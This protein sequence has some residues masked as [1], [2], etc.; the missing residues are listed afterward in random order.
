[1]SFFRVQPVLLLLILAVCACSIFSISLVFAQSPTINYQGKLTTSTGVAVPNGTYEMEFSLYTV[2]TGGTAVWTET[3]SGSNE[4]TVTDGLFSVMLGST[5]AL[6][7]VDFSQT[8]YLGVSIEADAE[9]SPRKILGTV[10]AAFEAQNAETFGT[11][12]TTSFVRSDQ[13]DSIVASTSGTLFSVIQNGAGTVFELFSGL[14]NLFTV[15]NSGNVGIGSSTPSAKLTVTGNG[16]FG[17]NLTATGTLAVTGT[18]TLTDLTL[19]GGLRDNAGNRGTLGMVLQTTG[20][21]TRWVATSTLGFGSSNVATLN[22]LT[23]VT[24]TAASTGELLAYNGSQWVD[25]AT[26]TLGIALSDTIGILA[27]TR[28]GTG[29]STVSVNQLLIGGAGNTWNQ[30]ATS[31]LGLSAQFTDSTGLAALLSDEQGTSGGFV[32][33]SSSMLTNTT[34]INASSTLGFTLSGTTYLTGALRDNNNATG[35][36]GMV[37]QTTG[38]ST[39]WVATSTL[40]TS[41]A[42][43]DSAGLAGLLSDEQGT[44]G[45]FVRASSSFL[46]APTFLNASSTNITL[47]GVT[48]LNGALRDNNNATGTLGMVLQTTGTSTRWVATSTLGTSAAFTDSTGLAALLSDEQGTSGGFVRASSSMLTN[49]TLINAS[50]TLGFTLSGT[51]YLTGALRDNNNA[52]GTL[53]MVLQTTGTSTRWVATSTLG[54][55]SS[56]VATLND[57]TDVTITAASTGELLAYNGSQWV[58]VATSTLGIALSDTIGILAPTRGGTGTSTVSVNQLLIGGAGNTWNQ[59][60]T[61]SLGL[62]NGTF[63][64]LTD[65]PSSYTANSLFYTNGAGTAVTNSANL[66]F[67]GTNLGVGSSTPNATLSV[68][69]DTY[70]TG[71][72][73]VG[74]VNT[75]P[76]TLATV[77]N[78]TIGNALTVQGTGSVF[79]GSVIVSYADAN[80]FGTGLDVRK[81]GTT[82]DATA[83]ITNG[84]ELGY[85]GFLGW[86]GSAYVRGAYVIANATENWTGSQRGTSY[87]IAV[88][89]NGSIANTVALTLGQDRTAQFFGNVNVSGTGTSAFTGAV[90]VTGTTTLTDLTLQG[91]LRDNAGSRGTLGMVLQTSGTST[92]WVATSSLGFSVGHSPVTLA[93]ENYLSLLGQEITANEIGPTNLANLDF[94]DFSCNGTACFLDAVYLS[95]LS[96][97][98]LFD[99][100]D[101][102]AMPSGSLFYASAIDTPAA[103]SIGAEGS[104]LRVVAGLPAWTATSTLGLGNGTFLGLSDTPSSYA[105]NRI[106]YMT[107]SA[108]TTSSGFVFDG[109]NLGVG[110]SSPTARIMIGDGAQTGAQ[111]FRNL[112]AV[113]DIW[114][115]QSANTHFG[116][117]SGTAALVMQD[118]NRDFPLV[119]GNMNA[120]P[121]VFGTQNQERM[122]IHSDGNVSIGTTTNSAGLLLQGDALITD[123]LTVGSGVADILA[124]IAIGDGTRT[125]RQWFRN[126]GSVSDIFIGQGDQNMFGLST[127]STAFIVQNNSNNSALAIGNLNNQ[128]LVFGT[129]DLERM[130]IGADGA[131]SINESL[132][133]G[134]GLS[135]EDSIT[136]TGTVTT[137]FVTPV[138][139][140][141]TTRINVPIYTP[142]AFAQVIAM[143]I[144]STAPSTA[145]VLSL[146]DDRRTA[147]QPTLAVFAPDE[148]NLVG[149]SW[150]GSNTTSYLKTTGGNVGI[151]SNTTDI[152]TFLGT[153]ESVFSGNVG[154]GSST[155]SAKLT[156]TGNGFFGGNLTATGTLAVTGTTTLTDLTLTGGLRDN[157]GNRGTLG[158]V[159]QTT[160]TSTRWVATSTLGFGSS[161]VATLNDLTDVTITAAST[162]EL[163]AYNGSQWVDVATST[164]GI[165]L[166]DTIGILAPTRGGTGT[167][168]VSVNQLLI[169][170]AGNTWNQI[171][172]SSLGLSAQFTDSTGLAALLSDE[173]GTSGGFVRASSSMLTNTT[174]INASSTLGFTLSGTTYLTGALRDNNNATGTL[175]M[176]LQTTGTSTRWVAT[177]TLGFGSSNVATL[178]DLTDVT[179]T[180][181]STG[182]LLAYNGS[183][184]VDVATSTLGIALSDTIGIL[185]P[186]RGGTGT[187]TV[188]VNQLLI[189]G[190][191]NTWNQ[192]ATSSLGLSAQFTDS[193]GLAALL[194]DEQGTSGGFVR[195][196]SSMLTNTTLINAS[197]TLG[198]TLSG[199]TYLTGA[200]RDNNNA[201]GT[202]G[203]VLQTTGTSTRWVATST[204]GFGSSNVATLN[205]LTD[206]TITAASTGELLAYNGS[207]WVDVAT[208][209]L[210]IALSDTI[211]I[212]A[213]TRGGTGTSTVSVNQLLIGGAGNTW[214]QI[215][216]S[217]LGLSAQFTDSTGLAALLSDEQGTSGGFVRASSSI[218]TSPSVFGILSITGSSSASE[219]YFMSNIP[220]LTGST[221]QNTYFFAGASSTSLVAGGTYNYG[222]GRFALRYLST[223][224]YNFAV[225]YEA[226]QGS[227]TALMTGS[228]NVALGYRTLYLNTS[229]SNNNAL[230]DRALTSNIDGSNNN[231]FGDNALYTNTTGFSNNAFGNQTLYFNTSGWDNNAFGDSALRS[232]TTGIS[233]NAF[234]YNALFANQTGSYNTA[235]GYFSLDSNQ[236]T[237]TIA[238]G[239]NVAE[240]AL[241]VDRGIFIGYNINAASTTQDDILNIGNLIFGTG[242]DGTG[243]TLS[244]GNIGIGTSTPT[245]KLSVDGDLRLT[246]GFRDGVNATGTL[247]MVLQTTGTSTRWVATSTLGLG[248]GTFLG[249]SDTPSSY[250]TDRILFMSSSGI[251]TSTNFTFNG[252][253]LVLGGT[254]G[255]SLGGD[256]LFNRGVADRLDIASGDSLNLVLGALQIGGTDVLTSSRFVQAANGASTTPSITF[257]ADTNTGLFGTGSDVLGFAT[258]GTERMRIDA[259]G[260]VGIGTTTT[261][262]RLSIQATGVTGTT[263]AGITQYFGLANSSGGGVQFGNLTEIVH[264]GTATTTI[265]GN[266]LRLTDS[267]SR[268]NVVRGLEVQVDRGTNTLGESTALSGFARTF[269]LRAT[270]R[271]D[272]GALFEPAGVYAETEGTTQGNALR[273]YSRTITSAAL[274]ALYQ[275][276]STFTGTGLLMNFGNDT[277]SY[278]GDFLNLQNDGS[279]VFTV[280]SNGTTTIGNGTTMAGLQ[281]GRGGLCVDNDGS[282]NASTTGRITSVSATVGNSDL[283]EMYF[284]SQELEPGEIVYATGGISVGRASTETTEKII[285]VVSTKPGMTLGFDDTSLNAGEA[286]YPIALT[287]RVPIK[288]S[289]EN[290]PIA[291]GDKIALSSIPGVGMKARP[292]D[293]VVGSALE[294]FDGTTAYSEGYVN[295]FGDDIRVPSVPVTPI[296]PKAEDGCSYGAGGAL[297]GSGVAPCVKNPVT[298]QGD[299]SGDVVEE[300]AEEVEETLSTIEVLQNIP[301]ETTT[302]NGEEVALGTV[303]M[304]VKLGR[305]D[306]IRT[307]DI[308]RQ[309]T[310]TSTDIVFGGTGESLW[311]RLKTLA[312][313]FVDGVL[314]VT[315]IKT[316]RV[317]TKEL[318]VDGLC[319]DADDLRALLENA[320]RDGQ[321]IE[322]VETPPVVEDEG[323]PIEETN[324]ESWS[325]GET[326]PSEQ[327]PASNEDEAPPEEVEEEATLEPEAE[328][329]T[330][331]ST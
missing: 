270:T 96:G 57:L 119:V 39:R 114:I 171:A 172:T 139:S 169:G 132:A 223:G 116:F 174:L 62:G 52:T 58:D 220:V 317:E 205:D 175:G 275:E 118:N 19:T 257:S 234:G 180:A 198:F 41:A 329:E 230:G 80:T 159:L 13:A 167:S 287:G 318:C 16:F 107:G 163:L 303:L 131:V 4:V 105:A 32:R 225:G 29:T 313:N 314:T 38:T 135:V 331:S 273:G 51:T 306:D 168:T 238:I 99:L 37:L 1:M 125:G 267:T 160:G 8:L 23:D 15:T 251:A 176:V 186:T 197:S 224:D 77:G 261:N 283:A 214:N 123:V 302:V 259:S 164:L 203:M 66:V 134:G 12:A 242:V 130:R 173:Q 199:T 27:P 136:F 110:T 161:N 218:L 138:G 252:S 155:P 143:G 35:T 56:N 109:T 59:I 2:S 55:G 258:A 184:W 101:M 295:Q 195:A 253:N 72:L 156:V 122:R 98:S 188:S 82:G 231:A 97:S 148:N 60:A 286:G 328:P 201:T 124:Q 63:L 216:T 11:L 103:L 121:L 46:T 191:G 312:Q 28:G 279:S 219:G 141:V 150:E 245:S 183:Q 42:F 185:A 140:F 5:T 74:V 202:L 271:G 75:T 237:G 323:S 106:P 47:A 226:L 146:F 31:S 310:S 281:I 204:L 207:Q 294:A 117:T 272:A 248:N 200:L 91:G 147:H 297:A 7:G 265:A 76:G 232:N 93:G 236:G 49:T 221:T 209:T 212:L 278:S 291:I 254:T 206:V 208:S 301:A 81:R 6:S 321:I 263:T 20:T 90:S 92:R 158:M 170:G 300:L 71:G 67:T 210:G 162:G 276:D 190:A 95:D 86:D 235:I 142:A 83:A 215:A 228:H 182:E 292:G 194:S 129:N 126:F 243:T 115:G 187:S 178:N 290:G 53:G 305:Y 260:N 100:A 112:G 34:L 69:G 246:G 308:M 120:Q 21:S 73:G 133:V 264:T 45:G 324:N 327:A 322:V 193:T 293:V 330:P 177:S 64:G 326:P 196:S 149:F 89:P 309:L 17:G 255:V 22:D 299:G 298:S 79:N 25:V 320:N 40:G 249:L 24:I 250:V 179:I 54:F 284:S 247:G 10:P 108:L 127:T 3:L 244:S 319:I 241:S 192:I 296:D 240:N 217:S 65:T 268:G 44:S 154:I 102:P 282:C 145:R 144:A 189:G 9:M 87:S 165:A 26:S 289:T 61:S 304:F 222:I 256:V 285:G 315:G 152:A 277:G 227:S 111:W 307:A 316:D 70:V 137:D 166:S 128:P 239:Y 18:T 48:Y 229:G 14:S 157:A 269:G 30:I 311:D 288:L 266:L 262:S 50:S 274:M 78:A 181:A 94:G 113:S 104:V 233:N 84:T 280:S 68:Q 151:R 36:L 43:S 211:G 153:G 33:A 88:T 325:S 213:P 85:H